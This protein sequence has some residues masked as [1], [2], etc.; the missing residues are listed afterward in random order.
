M[1]ICPPNA[2]PVQPPDG[3]GWYYRNTAF[4]TVVQGRSHATRNGL[5]AWSKPCSMLGGQTLYQYNKRYLR[6]AANFW[7][8][9]YPAT[10]GYTDANGAGSPFTNL[11]GVKG[12]HNGFELFMHCRC[13]TRFSGNFPAFGW[14]YFALTMGTQAFQPTVPET[15]QPTPMITSAYLKTDWTW[16]ITVSNWQGSTIDI[17]GAAILVTT[18]GWQ[19]R[20]RLILNQVDLAPAG[21]D[22]NTWSDGGRGVAACLMR[23]YPANTPVLLG[24]RGVSSYAYNGILPTPIALASVTVQQA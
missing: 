14:H 5:K 22:L 2:A 21:S 18:P 3:S 19:S 24:L 15:D 17:A 16:G 7:R 11:N 6:A 9:G 12:T 10:V 8:T 13:C 20:K 1:V 4:G 23:P